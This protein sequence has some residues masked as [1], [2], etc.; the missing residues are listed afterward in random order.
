GEILV[1]I[2]ADMELQPDYI[3][4]LIRPILDEGAVGTDHA[5]EEV[6]NLDNIWAYCW[7]K[8]RIPRMRSESIFFRAIERRTFLEAGGFDPSKGYFDDRTLYDK[9][10]TQAKVSP[11]AMCYHHNPSSLREVFS[12]SI[13]QGESYLKCIKH[14]FRFHAL[15]ILKKIVFALSPLVF[16]LNFLS[17][18]FSILLIPSVYE[19]FSSFRL[20]DKRFRFFVAKYFIF[21]YIYDSGFIIGLL[22][23][24]L[25]S[26]IGPACKPSNTFSGNW[27]RAW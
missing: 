18:S 4:E 6:A 13:W 23:F 11:K 22:K 17:P 5:V 2:D 1:F 19:L 26:S 3:Q 25:I 10:Q 24:I 20:K 8:E 27:L 7:G 21:S 16:L 15:Y 12:Q 14:S 9:L